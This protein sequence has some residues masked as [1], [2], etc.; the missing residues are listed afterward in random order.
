MLTRQVDTDFSLH[1]GH[2]FD[3]GLLLEDLLN[4]SKVRKV[5]FDVEDLA[6]NRSRRAVPF[7]CVYFFSWRRFCQ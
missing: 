2:Q 3:I 1:G 4:E 5:V 6:F 7:G